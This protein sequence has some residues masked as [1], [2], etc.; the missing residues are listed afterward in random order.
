MVSLTG[1]VATGKEIARTA[2]DTLKR[3]HLELG[4]KAPVL[5][6]D[7]ADVEAAVEGV[8]GAGFWN[9]GQDCTAASR[10]LAGPAVYEDFVA[11]LGAAAGSLA[12]GRP[13]GLGHR[14]GAAGVGLPARPRGGLHGTRARRRRT[15]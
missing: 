10:V 12:V 5:V 11:G 4:G 14:D 8:K 6:F 9:S 7:D 1:D 15:R 2:A 3:V 13:D